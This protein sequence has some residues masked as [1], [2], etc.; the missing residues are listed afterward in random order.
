[1]TPGPLGIA[2][3]NPSAEAPHAIA[4]RA[5]SRDVMQQ[6]L[7]RGSYHEE[8][9]GS[10]TVHSHLN[11]SLA[12]CHWK[13]ERT[14]PGII[15]LGTDVDCPGFAQPTARLSFAVPSLCKAST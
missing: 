2:E 11:F 4:I 9:A 15:S 6:I 3:T 10:L 14:A 7:V 5:S 8:R 1:M 13:G 12:Q